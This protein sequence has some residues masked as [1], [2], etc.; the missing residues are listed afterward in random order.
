MNSKANN[1]ERT[2]WASFFGFFRI[3]G[4]QILRESETM[5]LQELGL[6][7][8]FQAIALEEY[9]WNIFWPQGHYQRSNQNN[10]QEA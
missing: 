1:N 5:S 4:F 2:S 3:F 7:K 6:R 9:S 8:I 10:Q